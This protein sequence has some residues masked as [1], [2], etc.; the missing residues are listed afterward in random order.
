MNENPDLML[1]VCAGRLDVAMIFGDDAVVLGGVFAGEND[2][3]GVGSV[4][5]RVE[6]GRGLTLDGS[7]ASGLLRI[8]AVREDLGG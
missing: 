5:E 6:A 1:F 4:F 7:G 2:G 3:S 8:C